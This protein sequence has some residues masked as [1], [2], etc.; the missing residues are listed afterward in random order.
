MK[1]YIDHRKVKRRSLISNLASVGGLLIL[2]S[3]VAIP[4]FIP[5]LDKAAQVLMIAGMGLSMIGIYFANRWVRKPRPEDSLDQALKSLNDSYHLFHYPSLPC[6]HVL[7]TPIGVVVIEV[8][9][10]AGDFSYK[11]GRWKEKMNLGRALRYLVE[12]HLGDPIKNARELEEYLRGRLAQ[13]LGGE[14]SISI[15]SVVT[16]THPAVRLDVKNPPIPVCKPDKLCRYISK[17]T[18]RLDPAIYNQLNSFFQS[19]TVNSKSLTDKS[20]Y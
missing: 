11:D 14:N 16:F 17:K 9:N 6:E 20:N 5:S 4:L 10:L 15:H 1:T 19:L 8:F 12:E 18:T 2:L 7:L 3:S 13:A